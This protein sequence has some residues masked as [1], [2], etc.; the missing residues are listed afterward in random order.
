MAEGVGVS[1]KHY[2]GW[3]AGT[4]FIHEDPSFHMLNETMEK[5]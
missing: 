1:A 3:I 5:L 4:F 2:L